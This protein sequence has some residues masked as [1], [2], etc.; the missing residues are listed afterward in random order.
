M[1]RLRLARPRRLALPLLAAALAAGC[2]PAEP[3]AP[4]PAPSVVQ[5]MAGGDAEG[6]ER[7]LEPRD[8]DFPADHGTHPGFRT[9]WWY[10]TGNLEDPGGRRLGYQLTVFRNAL[11]P[12]SETADERPSAWATRQAWLAHFALTDPG[13][14]TFRSDQRLARGALGLA[15]AE[16]ADPGGLRAWVEDWS[17]EPVGDGSAANAAAGAGLGTLRLRARQEGAALD[18]RLT[19]LGPPVPHGDRGL[20]RKGAAPGDASF[21]YS[22]PRLAT[23]G[24]VE[25]GGRTLPVSGLS[26]LDREWSTSA[27]GPDQ[28]GWDWFALQLSD[29][30]DLMLYRLRRRGGGLDPVSSGTL[31]EPDGRARH[32]DAAAVEVAAAGRWRSPRS[33]ATYPSGWRLRVPAAD[34]EVALEPLLLDQ[35][36]DVGFRYW[37]GAVEARGVSAGRPVTGRGYVELTGYAESAAAENPPADRAY[38]EQ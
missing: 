27:L 13:A 10:F 28:E 32:L 33:G 5:A 3:P 25:V 35:E 11:A 2:R 23:E 16:L 30:R 12:A 34:L 22:I 20:S 6:Y 18:L 24:T 19:A 26:W 4:A 29:G 36:L 38:D 9:E 15:G 31:I 21:Y 1:E 17:V 7:A 37:E 8:L 14:G